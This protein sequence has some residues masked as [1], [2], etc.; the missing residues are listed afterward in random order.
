[1]KP[2]RRACAH[3]GRLLPRCGGQPSPRE[4]SCPMVLLLLSSSLEQWLFRYQTLATGVLALVGAILALIAVRLRI[5]ADDRRANE[6]ETC[7]TQRRRRLSRL[8][9]LLELQDF[10]DRCTSIAFDIANHMSS[11]GAAGDFHFSIPVPAFATQAD[12]LAGLE[13][14]EASTLV[15]LARSIR[16]VNGVAS[17]TAEFRSDD[18]AAQI[19][20]VHAAEFALTSES[21]L[22][23]LCASTGLPFFRLSDHVR[24]SMI[25]YSELARANWKSWIDEGD[26]GAS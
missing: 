23:G 13:G 24:T 11:A 3:S 14:D 16:H 26:E 22:H 12:D 17:D 5:Y 8:K 7:E 9:L 15:G 10:Q 6:A 20:K 21:L 4:L 18:D 25:H 19:I 1:M 2:V